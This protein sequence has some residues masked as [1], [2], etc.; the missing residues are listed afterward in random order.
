MSSICYFDCYSGASGDMLIAALLDKAVDF[1]WFYTEIKKLNLPKDS[2]N[3][4]KN[5][6]N[7]SSINSCKIDITLK[8]KDH[9]HRSYKS[10]CLIIDE[11]KIDSKSK[12][13]AKKIFYKL[14]TAEAQIHNKTIE[15]IH[16]HEVGALDSII[17]IVG[18]SICYN[19]LNIEKCYVSPLPV[20]AGEIN[21]AHGCLPVPAPATLEILKNHNITIKQNNFIKSECLTPTAA[22]ILCSIYTECRNIPDFN[23]ITSIGYGAGNKIFD[24]EVTSNLRFIVGTNN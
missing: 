12:D 13:L 14:G 4:E 8:E 19:S 2:F 16:F 1:N 17:D 6:V 22:A 11:S 10:I 18:F 21:C 5:Y 7:R 24:K 15:E 9:A 23:K 3:I 20:G